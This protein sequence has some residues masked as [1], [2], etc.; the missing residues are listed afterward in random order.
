M[1]KSPFLRV[2]KQRNLLPLITYGKVTESYVNELI[3]TVKDLGPY[4]V[5]TKSVALPHARPEAG[6]KELAISVGVLQSPV[7][8]GNHE[9]DPVKY[10]FGLSA[11]DSHTYLEAMSELID[12]LEVDKFYHLLDSAGTAEE[13]VDYKRFSLYVA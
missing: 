7:N 13:I 2:G 10:V 1:K 8:F 12:L 3:Q 9:N 4:V 6:V 5:I 11:L